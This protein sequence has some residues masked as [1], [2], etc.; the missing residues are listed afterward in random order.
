MQQY[1]VSLRGYSPALETPSAVATNHTRLFRPL[2]LRPLER[3][4][5]PRRLP[6]CSSPSPSCGAA[7]TGT[8]CRFRIRRWSRSAPGL[9]GRQS[10]AVGPCG[11]PPPA[12]PPRAEPGASRETLKLG[13]GGRESGRYST[14]RHAALV[15]RR[16]RE[17]ILAVTHLRHRMGRGP[18]VRTNNLHAA[19]IH[20]LRELLKPPRPAPQLPRGQA[21]LSARQR[22]GTCSLQ[23][24]D[25]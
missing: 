18:P 17:H 19:S 1:T 21:A 15:R 14:P 3:R 8:P 11:S 20:R 22:N 13:R 24:S 10:R 12:V 23:T 7:D 9:R 25:S 2:Q 16:S 5:Q 4:V 6:F